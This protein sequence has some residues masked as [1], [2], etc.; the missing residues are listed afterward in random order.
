MIFI[1]AL[2]RAQTRPVEQQK[3]RKKI[4]LTA[5][6]PDSDLV[7]LSSTAS[8]IVNI[9]INK[10]TSAEF[11]ASLNIESI[12]LQQS[13][14]YLSNLA[15]PI[16]SLLTLNLKQNEWDLSLQKPPKTLP[17]YRIQHTTGYSNAVRH[18]PTEIINYAFSMTIIS[19]E[20][21]HHKFSVDIR[22]ARFTQHNNHWPQPS[23]EKIQLNPVQSF[24]SSELLQIAERELVFFFD[25]DGDTNQAAPILNTMRNDSGLK[26]S[27]DNPFFH[28]LRVW[29]CRGEK[30]D[31]A[32]LG[33]PKL[34]AIQ[35]TI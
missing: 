25:Q 18:S 35:I 16:Y 30:V 3:A 29:R 34:G 8:H 14:L 5:S 26:L 1:Q 19:K 24:Y 31:I 9:K 32:L 28:G 6:K 10:D 17:S 21:Q 23:I 15:V 20:N 12:L 27:K 2:E 22:V 7:D 11:D 33:D 13:L 4:T